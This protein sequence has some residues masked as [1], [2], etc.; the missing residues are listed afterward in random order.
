MVSTVSRSCVGRCVIPCPSVVRACGPYYLKSIDKDNP[1]SWK[2]VRRQAEGLVT[3]GGLTGDQI[4]AD[5]CRFSDYIT[6]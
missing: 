4:V 2:M 6:V 1:S 5:T 3:H